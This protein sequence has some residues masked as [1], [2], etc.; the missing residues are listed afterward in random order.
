MDIG[1]VYG[2]V[3]EAVSPGTTWRNGKH[4][5]IV[6]V[7]RISSTGHV[8]ARR[9]DGKTWSIP[10]GAFL[11]SYEQLSKD[12]VAHM[13][14][15]CGSSSLRMVDKYCK[16]CQA[17]IARFKNAKHA[18][19]EEVL[20]TTSAKLIE[21]RKQD[22]PKQ[23]SPVSPASPARTLHWRIYARVVMEFYVDGATVIDALGAAE[24]QYPGME[25][26]DVHLLDS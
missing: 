3:A 25:V 19:E 26:T 4:G 8:S 13:C 24:V 11:G 17:A 9:R 5:D 12:D 23:A 7:L 15:R 16:D 14:A 1:L 21:Q 20:T 2:M 10:L 22:E 6:L 18:K